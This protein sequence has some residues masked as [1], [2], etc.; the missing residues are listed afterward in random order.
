MRL[1][2]RLL[3]RCR[4]RRRRAR[5]LSSD[6]H[7]GSLLGSLESLTSLSARTCLFELVDAMSSGVSTTTCANSALQTTDSYINGC[8]YMSSRRGR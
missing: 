3:Q 1:A 2:P 4:S 8:T 6:E 7:P 5:Q